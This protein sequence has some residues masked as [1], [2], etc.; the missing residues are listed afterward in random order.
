[1]AW[2]VHIIHTSSLLIYKY[3]DFN[4]QRTALLEFLDQIAI[5]YGFE[6]MKYTFLG[7]MTL[8]PVQ[9]RVCAGSAYPEKGQQWLLSFY[10]CSEGLPSAKL[11]PS[12]L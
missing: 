12:F 5:E 8:I 9:Y 4:P 10:S 3:N 1:M 2:Y 7:N 6:V 11:K